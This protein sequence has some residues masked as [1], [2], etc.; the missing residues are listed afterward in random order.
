MQWNRALLREIENTNQ[1]SFIPTEIRRALK[2]IAQAFKYKAKHQ[3]A[4]DIDSAMN[5][6]H[7]TLHNL[8]RNNRNNTTQKISIEITEH[9]S[10]PKEV[11]NDR[12]LVDPLIGIIYKKSTNPTNEKVYDDKY[13]H[14][15]VFTLYPRSSIRK[16]LDDL[17]ASLI[18]NREDNVARLEG[19]SNHRLEFINEIFVHFHVINPPSERSFIPTPK[20]LADKKAII[21]PQNKDDKCFL[22]A[23]GI[24]VSSDELGNKNLARISKK[25][26]KCCEQLK[27]DNIDFPPSTKDT[28]QFEKDNT[29]ISITIFE[30][31]GFHKRK[32]R[33]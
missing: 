29:N 6:V 28:E 12:D 24:S 3:N 1:P 25:L 21:N 26:L 32:R 11:L 31:D 2:G 19:A 27:I 7:D 16:L 18:R 14:S 23:V 4:V 17:I 13:H 33:W 22:Y 20:K 8:I 10:K 5:S 30:Y 9:F 15:N